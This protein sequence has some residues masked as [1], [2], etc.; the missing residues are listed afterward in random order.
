MANQQGDL[1][2]RVWGSDDVVYGPVDLTT[3]RNWAADQRIGRSTWIFQELTQTW[4]QA[5]DL[6]ELHPDGR[7]K[8]KDAPCSRTEIINSASASGIKTKDL[9]RVRVFAGFSD[10]YLERML[11]YLE[12]QEVCQLTTVTKQGSPGDAMF[13]VFEGEVR[14]RLMLHEH[15]TILATLSPGDIFGEFSLFDHGPRSADCVANRN[16][17]LLRLTVSRFQRLCTDAPEIATPLLIA[18]AKSLALRIRADNK[19]IKD[20]VLMARF[21]H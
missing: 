1:T 21:L 15:E 13:I 8:M 6:K 4:A 2:Y 12:L 3:L 9:R 14:V 20:A 10:A 11:T 17:V 5:A 16:S 7:A 18:V 19:K